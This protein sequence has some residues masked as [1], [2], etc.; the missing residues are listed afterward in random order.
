MNEQDPVC[1]FYWAFE[2]KMAIS[3][4]ELF[5]HLIHLIV[6]VAINLY[7]RGVEGTKWCSWKSSRL[8][9]R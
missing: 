6:F 7:S 2:A 9:I 1:Q 3:A 8:G 5:K 4:G